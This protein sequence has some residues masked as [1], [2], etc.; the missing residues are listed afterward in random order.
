[1]KSSKK[2]FTKE[3][4]RSRL[5]MSL[6]FSAVVFVILV[7]TLILSVLIT[8]FFTSV[9]GVAENDNG[10]PQTSQM[11][12]LMACVSLVIGSTIAFITLK[13]PLKPINRIINLLNRLAKGDFGVR[14]NLKKPFSA[15]PALREV[16]DS[17][18]KMASELEQT[19]ML[20]SDFI[21]NF[22]HEFKTPIVSIAG[23]AKL[24]RRGNLTEEQK[25]EYIDIIAEESMRLS[26]MATNVLNLTKVE[27]QT[28]LSDVT[29]YNLSEQIRSSV[30]LL[31]PKWSKKDIEFELEFDEYTVKANEELLKQVWINLIDN[32]VK[33]SDVGGTVTVTIS[34]LD[35]RIAVSVSNH[36][37]T[38]SDENKAKIFGKFYQADKSHTSEGNG[39][40]L[41]IVKRICELHSGTVDVKSDGGVN[42]FTV[43]LPK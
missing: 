24:L 25:A 30:L 38:I 27:N 28:I 19:E 3:E 16:S 29:E 23:F 36:G 14:L 35:D 39:V 1:M 12:I 20:R 4:R 13:I 32:A 9:L 10:I 11:L 5:S 7:V 40:G 41:A 18:N 22:S 8:Y 31:E 17:F 26:Y 43:S 21:N 2:K 6:L 15:H 42:T 34:N 37:E 33:F